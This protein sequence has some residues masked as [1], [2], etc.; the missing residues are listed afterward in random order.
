MVWDRLCE[1]N[2]SSPASGS[3]TAYFLILFVF[4]SVHCSTDL[5]L[6]VYVLFKALF[7][8]VKCVWKRHV[9]SQNDRA[10]LFPQV[11]KIADKRSLQCSST[12][13]WGNTF[14][15][16]VLK[17]CSTEWTVYIIFYY[18]L[19]ELI[20]GGIWSCLRIWNAPRQENV[21][22]ILRT[23]VYHPA[24]DDAEMQNGKGFLTRMSVS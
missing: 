23:H 14:Y 3:E 4:G 12:V 20:N 5:A 19:E 13:N 10:T 21:L 9:I 1:V 15:V 18:V 6:L 24:T 7:H 2:L 16:S 11:K 17:C 22:S 8:I